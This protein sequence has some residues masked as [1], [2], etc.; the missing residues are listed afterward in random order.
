MQLARL[1]TAATM[2]RILD[3]ALR[4]LLILFGLLVAVSSAYNIYHALATGDADPQL[5]ILPAVT[6]IPFILGW[7]IDRKH[8]GHR[9]ALLFLVM[10]YASALS[11]IV[12]AAGS[13]HEA[14]GSQWLSP[15]AES[16]ARVLGHSLYIPS[17][18]IP[19]FLIPLFFPTGRLL[20][21]RWRPVVAIIVV[22]MAWM[23][24]AT[25]LRPW[26]WPAYGIPD[27][28][29]LNGIPGSEPFFDAALTLQSIV[30]VPAELL[31]IFSVLLRFFRARGVEREQMKWP[32]L[33]V[34][35]IVGIAIIRLLIP[36]L[37]TWEV[38]WGYPLTW[39]M[40]MLLPI[41]V[42]I[43]ILHH[44]LWD[45]DIAISRT[46]L[47]GGLTVL[48]VTLY[49]SIVG[50]LGYLFQT[51]TNIYS[52]LVAAAII[53]V[54]FQPLRDR[55]Q[56][57]VDRLLFG[58]RNDPAAVLTRLA[59]Q[60]QTTGPPSALLP[61]LVETIAL[62]LKLPYAAI[63]LPADAEHAQPVAA[64]GGAPGRTESLPLTYHQETIGHL[65]VGQR[66]PNEPF[67]AHESALL[68]AVAAITATAVHAVQL[69]D[70]LRHSRR[71]IIAAREDER[72]R[73]RRDLHDGLG[74]QLA[75]QTLGLEAVAQL[76]PENPQKAQALLVSLMKQAEEATGDVRRLVYDL[77][78]PAL[79]DLGLLGALR[80][81]ADR[82]E[83]GG[84]RFHFI[85]GDPLPAL[86]AAVETAVYRIVQEAMTNVVRHAGATRCTVRLGCQDSDFI[87]EIRDNGRGLPPHYEAGVGLL[88]MEERVAELNGQ[89]TAESL[90]GGGTRVW[91]K[92]PLEAN[93]G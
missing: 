40:A 25:A 11:I 28:R 36:E 56:R 93:G 5:L 83:V 7:L 63:W 35:I 82:Y 30:T 69:S 49:V 89:L 47:Y 53:A 4:A 70:E 34:L 8:P 33:A 24:I 39:T 75:S 44:R 84:L 21:A 80:Q 15:A 6:L 16:I 77:R 72:R 46:L 90:P 81:R 85:V 3:V 29:P 37:E 52:G 86:P 61:N 55:L 26:P 20:S 91:A 87:A 1:H 92:L 19:L 67:D 79:D 22:S 51:Q 74:P 2:P 17:V 59:Q 23:F 71:R 38:A 27:T 50:L 45:I 42:G 68:A 66:G 13:L 32:I 73:L 43:A 31:A 41:S 64:W 62:T 76:M 58:E 88:A 14:R 9:I 18:F 48:I 57:R 54:L 78:P 60:T 10:A 65:V 12:V